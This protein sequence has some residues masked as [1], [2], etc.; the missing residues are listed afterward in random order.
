MHSSPP[1][2]PTH[3]HLTAT[4]EPT[5]IHATYDVVLTRSV[6]VCVAAMGSSSINDIEVG[7][8]GGDATRLPPAHPTPTTSLARR[9]TGRATSRADLHRA[10]SGNRCA[11]LLVLIRLKII[12][13]GYKFVKFSTAQKIS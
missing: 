6:F 4:I 3:P 10:L 12:I 2:T 8:R 11:Q 5:L 9:R 7:H 1:L 13:I